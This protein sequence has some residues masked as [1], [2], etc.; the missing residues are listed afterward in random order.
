MVEL[1]QAQQNM[2]CKV[3]FSGGWQKA[4]A[5]VTRIYQ[6]VVNKRHGWFFKL[7]HELTDQDDHLFF[8]DLSIKGTQRVP[9]ALWGRK[10]SDHR[11]Y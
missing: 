2:A 8:E 1:K 5:I 11:F 3:K 10:V 9:E 6:R 4:R 7:A